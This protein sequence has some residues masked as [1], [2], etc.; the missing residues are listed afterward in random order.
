MLHHQLVLPQEQSDPKEIILLWHLRF[1]ASGGAP[2]SHRWHS[3]KRGDLAGM[4][5]EI[6]VIPCSQQALFSHRFMD[7]RDQ[8]MQQFQ[9]LFLSLSSKIPFP[10]QVRKPQN[11]QIALVNTKLGTK[12]P[13]IPILFENHWYLQLS[14]FKDNKSNLHP[15][16]KWPTQSHLAA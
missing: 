2:C 13:S 7:L 9:T 4:T 15:E 1:W 5:W 3:H 14:Q 8:S 11:C 6:Q 16:F 12:V 10:N